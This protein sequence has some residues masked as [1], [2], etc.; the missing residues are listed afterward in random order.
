M[1]FC[2]IASSFDEDVKKSMKKKP[3]FIKN[4]TW[5]S[6][7]RNVSIQ[8]HPKGSTYRNKINSGGVKIPKQATNKKGQH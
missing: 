4:S 8:T 3:Y 1:G 5:W 6:T 7:C 2:A